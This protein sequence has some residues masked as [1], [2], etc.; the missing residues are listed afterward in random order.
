ME[1]ALDS[2]LKTLGVLM[3]IDTKQAQAQAPTTPGGKK[4]VNNDDMRLRCARTAG[5]SGF[6]READSP[7]HRWTKENMQGKTLLY[8]ASGSN[9][10]MYFRRQKYR[11][12]PYDMT[13]RK[14]LNSILNPIGGT[15]DD[16]DDDDDKVEEALWIPPRPGPSGGGGGS[17][18]RN[19]ESFSSDVCSSDVFFE[20]SYHQQTFPCWGPNNGG[21]IMFS[22]GKTDPGPSSSSG[23]LLPR[24]K[25]LEDLRESLKGRQGRFLLSHHHCVDDSSSN[26]TAGSSNGSNSLE[27]SAHLSVSPTT[28]F[29]NIL[30]GEASFKNEV[31]SMSMLIEKLDVA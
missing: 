19:S 5:I 17:R 16:D 21:P 18:T 10:K 27:S 20:E 8:C 3:E 13:K 1:A 26:G 7:G 22:S 24:S 14:P 6:R 12:S 15:D 28:S 9:S 29:L 11:H 4:D 25:S 23:L 2:A 30:K 31:D